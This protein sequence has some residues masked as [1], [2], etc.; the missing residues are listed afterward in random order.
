MGELRR[1]FAAALPAAGGVVTL[2]A[3]DAQH[4]R[5]LRLRAGA[6]VE[7]FDACGAHAAATLREVSRERVVCDVEARVNVEPPDTALHLVVCLPKGKKLDDI[8]RALTELGV[9]S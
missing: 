8:T 2:D 1:I 9:M 7:L 5:V 4:V 3:E 6:R